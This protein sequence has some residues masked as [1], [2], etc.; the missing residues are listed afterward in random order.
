M[1]SHL[2]P[3]KCAE[4]TNGCSGHQQRKYGRLIQQNQLK[5]KASEEACLLCVE[6]VRHH[7]NPANLERGND[8]N[9]VRIA[10]TP[11]IIID[12]MC[13]A[14]FITSPPSSPVP[15][16]HRH[17]VPCLWQ[18]HEKPPAAVLLAVASSGLHDRHSRF[19]PTTGR[20][21][22]SSSTGSVIFPGHSVL[23]HST[24]SDHFLQASAHCKPPNHPESPESFRL[25]P[26]RGCFALVGYG[27]APERCHLH[28]EVW[29]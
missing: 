2:S 6:L 24:S 22:M 20:H 11:P 13:F 18:V 3:L 10:I 1:W 8:K 15:A 12:T 17:S 16:L 5:R 14:I 19:Q 28:P 4:V 23:R 9:T 25:A 7:S 26:E 21:S 27:S 29:R